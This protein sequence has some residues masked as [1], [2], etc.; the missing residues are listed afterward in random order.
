MSPKPASS[1]ET[2]ERSSGLIPP[3]LQTRF[4]GTYPSPA[5]SHMFHPCRLKTSAFLMLVMASPS[6]SSSPATDWEVPVAQP[7]QGGHAVPRNATTAETRSWDV[8]WPLH[9]SLYSLSPAHFLEQIR[10]HLE[11]CGHLDL[12]HA[13]PCSATQGNAFAWLPLQRY[14]NGS[15]SQSC[16]SLSLSHF[17]KHKDNQHNDFVYSGNPI[18]AGKHF[19]R[20]DFLCG[21]HRW[22]ARLPNNQL[23]DAGANT[24]DPLRVPG[25]T[26]R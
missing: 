23:A 10:E 8:L 7:G 11:P 2:S 24:G 22:G 20:V 21:C 3:L 16:R 1:V 14:V 9:K 6:L 4:F 13:G 17:E 18:T 5:S 19:I 26:W 12:T 25:H 15:I